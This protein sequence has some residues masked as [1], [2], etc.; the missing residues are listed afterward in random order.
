MVD[1][2]NR[3]TGEGAGTGRKKWLPLAIGA[4]LLL[5]LLIFGLRSCSDR[6]E[7][8]TA[9]QTTGPEATI[10]PAAGP[11]AGTAAG[12]IA[13]N[14]GSFT[15]EGL[16]GYLS[17]TGPADA[18]GRAFGLDRVTFDTGSA[19]LDQQDQAVIGEVAGVLK[20]FPNASVTVTGYADPAGDA[21]ANKKLAAQ[22][23]TAVKQA[24]AAQGL[25]AAK[26]MTNVVGETGDAAVPENRRV[27][28]LV[29]R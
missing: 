20:Q 21:A 1:V 5:L 8:A 22:R 25:Q 9:N 26:L 19:T 11:L 29:K 14:D 28:L 17:E 15:V 12:T 13:A 3:R 2:D 7:T 4:G 23:T 24:L 10:D 27:E 18:T 6:D 16:R